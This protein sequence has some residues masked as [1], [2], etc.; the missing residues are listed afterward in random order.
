MFALAEV[1]AT[2][3]STDDT[4]KPAGAQIV[5][6]QVVSREQLQGDIGGPCY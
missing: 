6:V 2:V 5:A 1:K 3:S 4:L